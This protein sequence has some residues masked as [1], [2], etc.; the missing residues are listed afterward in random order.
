MVIIIWL[1]ETILQLFNIDDRLV[2]F[3]VAKK[4]S[5]EFELHVLV[6]KNTAQ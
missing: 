6:V 1:S 2:L 4:M 3:L 5:D